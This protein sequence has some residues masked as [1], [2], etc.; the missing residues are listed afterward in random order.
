M[1][2]PLPLQRKLVDRAKQMTEEDTP[3]KDGQKAELQQ[4]FEQLLNIFF[5]GEPPPAPAPASAMFCCHNWIRPPK[6]SAAQAADIC[7][8]TQG[9]PS[10]CVVLQ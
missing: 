2:L 1:C 5:S 6:R 3:D 7:F 8:C 4:E 10:A 9:C